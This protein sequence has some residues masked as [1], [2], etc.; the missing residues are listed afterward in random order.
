MDATD[1]QI[2]VVLQ[3]KFLYAYEAFSKKAV[4]LLSDNTANPA[5]VESGVQFGH[6]IYGEEKPKFTYYMAPGI[7]VSIS[8]SMAVGLTA[9]TLILERKEGLLDR[10]WVA[11]VNVLEVVLAHAVTQ[12]FIIVIQMALMVFFLIV[13]FDVPCEGNVTFVLLLVILQGLTGMSAGLLT[14]AVFE[15]EIGAVQAALGLNYPILLLS[16]VLWP[17][18]AMPTWLQYISYGLPTTYAAKSMRSIMGRG[19]GIDWEAVWI[20]YLSTIAWL[21]IFLGLSAVALRRRK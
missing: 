9:T 18:E 7:L 4:T 10:S 5:A 14:S 13:V 17:I 15:T 6:N 19:W 21:V 2:T 8:F 3:T 16:G 12:L 11:G 20:G 1:E